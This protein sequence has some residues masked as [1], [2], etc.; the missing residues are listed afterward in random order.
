MRSPLT[1]V[2]GGSRS[3][4]PTRPPV[5][6]TA[7]QPQVT[8]WLT[9][10]ERAQ[11]D[12]ATGAALVHRDTL[13]AVADDLERARADAV[14]V[15]AARVGA[16][17]ARLLARCVRG[18]PAVTFAGVVT[19]ATD[20]AQALRA[21]HLLGL[22]G[23]RVLFDCRTPGG[24]AA[25]RDTLAACDGSDA[26]RRACVASVLRAVYGEAD[27]GPRPAGLAHFFGLAFAPDVTQVRT[28]AARLNVCAPTLTSRFF[29]AGLPS[30]RRY[31]TWARLVWAARLGEAPGRSVSAI[32]RQLDA[33]SL[34][35]FGRSVRLHTGFSPSEFRRRFSGAAL[36]DRYCAT[37]VTP[38][39]DRLRTFDPM[40]EGVPR[41][42]T[43]AHARPAPC[44]T[45]A[46]A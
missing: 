30:P 21:A 13:A 16:T 39:R 43:G 17:D 29:R 9:P 36:L 37:L 32:A 1:L 28:L 44:R 40:G 4:A 3:G 46:A 34:Q 2:D 31:L 42:V 41:Q 12:A 15:S 19:D 10:R 27:G 45:R 11:V 7:G 8:T 22:S 20:S 6:G 24:W 14:L 23:V 38:H 35:G 25:L 26:F 18:H 33:S 5:S